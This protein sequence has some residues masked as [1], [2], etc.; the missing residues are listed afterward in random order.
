MAFPWQLIIPIRLCRYR[1]FLFLKSPFIC[2]NCFSTTS[3]A[4][5]DRLEWL[6]WLTSRE[7]SHNTHTAPIT[8]SS[9]AVSA[10]LFPSTLEQTSSGVQSAESILIMPQISCPY[11]LTLFGELNGLEKCWRAGYCG[12]NVNPLPKWSLTFLTFRNLCSKCNKSLIKTKSSW[13]NSSVY[14]S[15]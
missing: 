5:R 6:C 15:Q 4:L 12:T 8:M 10:T 14:Q 3:S 2:R 7:K 11:Q 9:E 1:Q 13:G